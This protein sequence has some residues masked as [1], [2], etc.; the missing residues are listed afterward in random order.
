[1][2]TDAGISIVNKGAELAK[3][4]NNDYVG[5]LILCVF[6]L[7]AV[8]VVALFGGITFF[9]KEKKIADKKADERELVLRNEL[10]ANKQW[11]EEVI[12]TNQTLG[13]TVEKLVSQLQDISHTVAPIPSIKED[14]IHIKAGIEIMN[15]RGGK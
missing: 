6:I 1:M 4:F 8:I 15:G 14:T 5:F 7:A 2:K 10:K 13:R 11:V 12:V 9:I 3:D